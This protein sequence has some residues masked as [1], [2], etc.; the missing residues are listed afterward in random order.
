MS[1]HLHIVKLLVDHNAN[2][3]VTVRDPF[4][5]DLIPLFT[6]ALGAP[7]VDFETLEF[8]SEY[9]NCPD[10]DAFHLQLI[11]LMR[12]QTSARRARPLEMIV[13]ILDRLLLHKYPLY[14]LPD[15]LL[16]IISHVPENAAMLLDTF[17]KSPQWKITNTAKLFLFS[18]AM[19]ENCLSIATKHQDVE[20]VKR[21]IVGHETEKHV[22]HKA[23]EIA[24][25]M[26]NFELIKLLSEQC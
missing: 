16:Y 19:G 2:V 13:Q 26:R 20:V 24:R 9:D 21:L 4:D 5:S 25:S 23:L 14:S 6:F 22:F 18:D 7:F 15:T 10:E 8:L 12:L 17:M 3:H 1:S 11:C